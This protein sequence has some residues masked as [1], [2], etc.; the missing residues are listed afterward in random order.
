[1]VCSHA[2]ENDSKNISLGQPE[3]ALADE[4]TPESPADPASKRTPAQ[5]GFWNFLEPLNRLPDNP[6]EAAIAVYNT[7]GLAPKFRYLEAS[8]TFV[9]GDIAG[10]T[11]HREHFVK[12]YTWVQPL[13]EHYAINVPI[14]PERFSGTAKEIGKKYKQLMMASHKCA[15]SPANEKAYVSNYLEGLLVVDFIYACGT[16]KDKQEAMPIL[17]G[18]FTANALSLPFNK[19]LG[20]SFIAPASREIGWSVMADFIG[21]ASEMTRV[22]IRSGFAEYSPA[23]NVNF[24]KWLLRIQEQHPMLSKNER[25]MYRGHIN[26]EQVGVGLLSYAIYYAHTPEGID[27]H[28]APGSIVIGILFKRLYPKDH[29]A[30]YQRYQTLLNAAYPKPTGIPI[31]KPNHENPR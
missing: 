18:V 1:M 24:C 17:D 10:L 30:Q 13:L 11:A 6:S 19:A 31:P 14:S 2:Q 9:L 8:K 22:L 4:P 16:P 26:N 5:I 12:S 21:Q 15:D 3:S 20:A 25:D 27:P 23:D 29:A 28:Q 7:K